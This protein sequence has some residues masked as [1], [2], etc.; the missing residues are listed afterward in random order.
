VCK[1]VSGCKFWS[2]KWKL[3]IGRS[4]GNRGSQNSLRNWSSRTSRMFSMILINWWWLW[5]DD[6]NHP[7]CELEFWNKN[8]PIHLFLLI[9]IFAKTSYRRSC[10]V[11]TR[12]R[13]FSIVILIYLNFHFQ[14][15]SRSSYSV[16]CF[17]R[18]AGQR[19]SQPCISPFLSE[20]RAEPC[21]Q[22]PRVAFLE[23]WR[24]PRARSEI[25]TL[26]A[27]PFPVQ[28]PRLPQLAE[29]G[30]RMPQGLSDVSG[31]FCCSLIHTV[32]SDD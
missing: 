14:F 15:A 16:V 26:A 1:R 6:C 19:C 25:R 27:S 24:D 20:P 28:S 8:K 23:G 21:A 12:M 7:N 9:S 11:S 5:N 30:A 18:P 32:V 13:T 2:V 10:T 17:V 3:R 22:P 4:P 29:R 31:T